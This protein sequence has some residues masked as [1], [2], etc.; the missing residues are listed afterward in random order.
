M[1]ALKGP[2]AAVAMRA[3]SNGYRCSPSQMGAFAMMA[4]GGAANG[5]LAGAAVGA[6]IGAA[7]T[8]ANS[9]LVRPPSPLGFIKEGRP[10]P[11]RLTAEAKE[12]GV[13]EALRTLQVYRDVDPRAYDRAA[14][15]TQRIMNL[16]DRFKMARSQGGDGVRDLALMT[17]TAVRADALWRSMVRSIMGA[18]DLTGAEVTGAAIMDIH[19]WSEECIASSR[20]DFLLN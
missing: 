3:M 17:R 12:A 10:V 15:L 14:Q 4:L 18:G 16:R 7:A 13:E 2:G 1:S 9:L 19:V 6:G 5:A 11:M 20:D 8:L